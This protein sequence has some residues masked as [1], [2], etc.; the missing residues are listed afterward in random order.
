VKDIYFLEEGEEIRD[1]RKLWFSQS[2]LVLIG[3]LPGC[4]PHEFT[5]AGTFAEK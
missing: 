2:F 5:F 4:S 3:V 1:E